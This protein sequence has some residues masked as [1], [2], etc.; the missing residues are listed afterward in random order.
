MLAQAENR[1]KIEGIL[2][3]V[4]IKPGSFT[5]KDGTHVESIGGTITIRVNQEINKVPTELEI[6]VHMFA[7]KFTNKG[8]PNP[9]YESISKIMTDYVSIA[10]G[11]IEKADKIRITS[12]SIAMNEYYSQNSGKLVSFPRI[13]ASFVS[14][15]KAEEF[16]PEASFSAVFVVGKAGYKTDADGVETDKYEIKGILPQYG[17]KVDVIPFYALSKGVIDAV[18]NYWNEGDTVKVNGVLNFTSTTQKVAIPVDFGEPKEEIRT[19]SISELVITGGTATP[20]DGDMAYDASEIKTALA[21]R[22]ARL[23][24]SKSKPGTKGAAPAPAKGGFTASDLGF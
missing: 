8:D 6:P 13:S 10:A 7:S 5:K 2:S 15:V 3:E 19:I 12:G 20:L 14:R 24:A 4:D 18:S 23:E 9:A 16:H 17:G 1:V 22:T 21:E 11:G